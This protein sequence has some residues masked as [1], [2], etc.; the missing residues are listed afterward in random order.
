MKFTHEWKR[1]KKKWVEKHKRT[2]G[3]IYWSIHYMYNNV[4]YS[5]GEYDTEKL[6]KEDLDKYNM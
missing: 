3:E 1:K 4:E 6:A 5:N 2:N